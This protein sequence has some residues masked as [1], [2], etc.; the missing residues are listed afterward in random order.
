MAPNEYSLGCG[1]NTLNT[2]P[3]TSLSQLHSL[4]AAK[5][6]T[7]SGS[8]KPLPSAPTMEGV[9]AKIMN[10]FEMKWEQF[11]EEKGFHGFLDEYYGRWL[12][13]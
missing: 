2:L 7:S 8:S 13:S 9:F 12:H 1:I 4:L 6:P 3:T 11:I 5:H 10:S